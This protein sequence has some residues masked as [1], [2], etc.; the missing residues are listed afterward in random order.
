MLTLQQL[1]HAWNAVFHT[2]QSTAPLVLFRI[3]MGG[4]LLVNCAAADPA[5]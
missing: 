2:E 5:D 1:M 3:L 4:L